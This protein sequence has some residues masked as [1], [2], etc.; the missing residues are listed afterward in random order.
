MNPQTRTHS[1]FGYYTYN[2][3]LRLH[4]DWIKSGDKGRKKNIH[5]IDIYKRNKNLRKKI[6]NHEN[7]QKKKK[8]PNKMRNSKIIEQKRC[9]EAIQG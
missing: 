7:K 8:I 4:S 3:W 5:L 1:T 6:E 9:N 2:S